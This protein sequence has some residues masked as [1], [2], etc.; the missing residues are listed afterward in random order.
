MGETH[1]D[2]SRA[3]P[4]RDARGPRPS[5][6]G[7]LRTPRT[8]VRAPRGLGPRSPG[9]R[10]CRRTA[11]RDPWAV[12]RGAGISATRARN[13]A[14]APPGPAQGGPSGGGGLPATPAPR[15]RPK[16]KR[17]PSEWSSLNIHFMAAVGKGRGRLT[18]P[19]SSAYQAQQQRRRRR[20]QRPHGRWDFRLLEPSNRPGAELPAP[21][22]GCPAGGGATQKGVGQEGA[23]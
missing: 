17:L 7:D 13:A 11:A 2:D 14:S 1:R 9:S 12:A 15:A 4:P 5:S 16:A 21:L 19:R 22:T 18:E 3:C 20:R 23:Q 6:L 8:L 10:Q